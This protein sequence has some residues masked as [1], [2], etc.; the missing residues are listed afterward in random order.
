M[1]LCVIQ[2]YRR[3][4]ERITDLSWE[5]LKKEV[6]VAVESEVIYLQHDLF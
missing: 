4:S 2:I 5:I 3:G 6:T 1:C